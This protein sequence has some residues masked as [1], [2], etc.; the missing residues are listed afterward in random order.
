MVQSRNATRKDL[1]LRQDGAHNAAIRSVG[2]SSANALLRGSRR[3]VRPDYG[4]G[5]MAESSSE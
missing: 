1:Q 2:P 5:I 4:I 3:Y